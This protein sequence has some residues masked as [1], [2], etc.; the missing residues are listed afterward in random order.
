MEH[1]PTQK[2]LIY[3]DND[4]HLYNGDFLTIDLNELMEKV[5]LVITSPPYNVG[6]NYDSHDDT[7]NYDEYIQFT[8]Q[9][10]TKVYNLLQDDGRICI[11]I[12]MNHNKNGN[13]PLLVDFVNVAREVGFQYKTTIIW[14]KNN[15]SKRSAWGSWLSASAPSVIPHVEVILVM[16]KYQWKRKTNGKSTITKEEFVKWT[17]GI[18]TFGGEKKTKIGHP[19]PFPLELPTRCIK[20]FSYESDVVLDP[21]VGS[22]TTLVA[23]KNN[24]RIGIG[25]ELSN[26]YCNITISRL[27]SVQQTL[28][29]I[30][31]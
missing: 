24:K 4:V 13:I 22:G 19:S 18:W 17:N 28:F 6:I 3:Y 9:W 25:V 7:V 30:S 20:L 23:C 14:N 1:V 29:T 16:Y 12:P 15:I 21:F 11:N 10:L 5:N 8:E 31:E 26:K 27:N 2:N